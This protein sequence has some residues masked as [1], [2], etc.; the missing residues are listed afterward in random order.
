VSEELSPNSLARDVVRSRILLRL[1]TK[2]EDGRVCVIGWRILALHAILPAAALL[3]G[4]A[5]RTSYLPGTGRGVLDHFGFHALFLSAPLLA[6]M[7]C[8]FVVKLSA[9]IA[10]PRWFANIGKTADA[11]LQGELINLALGRDKRGATLLALM[12]SIGVAAVIANASSTRYPLLVYGEDVFDSIMHPFGYVVA[13]IFLAY[14]WVYLLPLVAYFVVV[15]TV[16][17]VRIAHLVEQSDE[18]ELRCFAADGCGGFREL[19]TLMTSVVFLYVPIAVVVAA[20]SLTHANF[21]PTL[22][23]SAV[24]AVLVPAQLFL[25]FLRLHHVMVQLKQRKL[26]FMEK[27]LTAAERVLVAD[28]PRGW[29]SQFVAPYLRLLAGASLHQQASEMTTWPYMRKDALKWVTPF[30]PLAISTLVKQFIH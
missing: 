16:A 13:R 12:R 29:E 10:E 4:L 8:R 19:G 15:A 11:T 22:K 30:V 20:L 5:E 28:P 3:G 24:L 14:Y 23:L 17:T 26:V 6:W 7:L 25:P 18:Y 2:S 27:V 9:V 1:A 21:Y